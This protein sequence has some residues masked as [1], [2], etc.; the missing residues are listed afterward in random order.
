MLGFLYVLV[1]YAVVLGLHLVVPGRWVDGYV[2]DPNTSKPLRY[3]LNGLRVFFLAS[4]RGP[5]R[6]GRACSRG[7]CSTCTAGR[8]SRS[9]CA[10]GLVFTAGDRA[11]APPKVKNVFA[12]LY[13]GRLDNPQ[14]ARRPPRRQDVASTSIGA[15]M[16]ELNLLSFAARHVLLH[17]DDPSPGVL[18]LV[19][20]SSASS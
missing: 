19:W 8:C 11:P 15:I 9:A 13:L 14:C 16:L 5:A 10:L 20:R 1:I 7:T 18:S 4:P 12:D 17:R 2:I 6:A 3:H